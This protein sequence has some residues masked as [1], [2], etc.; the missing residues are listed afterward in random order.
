LADYPTA[1]HS[2][3]DQGM[4]PLHLAFRNESSWDIVEELLTAF[5]Q[6]VYISDRKARTPLQ[7]GH[8]SI[9]ASS[10]N[11]VTSQT[12]VAGPESKNFRSTVACLDL[13]SQIAVS[14]ERQRGQ[15][16]A[17]KLAEVRVTQMQDSHLQTLTTLKR[18]WSSEA[19]NSK[20]QLV[21]LQQEKVVLESK[22]QGQ[23]IDLSVSR[24]TEKDLAD[25][26]RQLSVALNLAN[27]KQKASDKNPKCDQFQQTNQLLRTMV[28]DLVDQQ[29]SY[30]SQFGDLMTKYDKLLEERNQVQ[31]AF[32]QQSKVQAEKEVKVVKNFKV[33]LK[34]R[35]KT[36]SQHQVSL[37][38]EKKVEDVTDFVERTTQHQQNKMT[39]QP[40]SRSSRVDG[41][42]DLSN[43]A[44]PRDVS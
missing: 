41:V 27:E 22:L 19:E 30:H 13:Y 37:E 12:V 6:A 38:E 39:P 2:K 1:A 5:P 3:D 35:E 9:G 36:L 23:A 20:H 8:R 21:R 44:S 24:T 34:D 31:L 43:L 16:E 15:Q 4:L 42:I 26:L 10:D 17:R 25:K 29:K 33:W 18:E 28:E 7:C 32:L 14:Q 11:S 40:S